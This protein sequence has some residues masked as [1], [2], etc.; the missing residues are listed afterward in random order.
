MFSFIIII[1]YDCSCR[2]PLSL[3]PLNVMEF[4]FS[5]DPANP[6]TVIQAINHLLDVLEQHKCKDTIIEGLRTIV[7]KTKINY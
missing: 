5:Y 6:E 3:F 7:D 2:G 1:I 4:C